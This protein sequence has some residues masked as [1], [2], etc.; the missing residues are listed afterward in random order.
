MKTM[1][2]AAPNHSKENLLDEIDFDKEAEEII[3]TLEPQVSKEI[4]NKVV[5]AVSSNLL[6]LAAQAQQT[7]TKEYN[8]TALLRTVLDV[9]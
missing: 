3:R 9:G 4:Y 6:R 1:S 7:P 8:Y 5:K 2:S